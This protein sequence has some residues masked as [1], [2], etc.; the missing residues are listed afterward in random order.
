MA[1]TPTPSST[2]YVGYVQRQPPI[3][4]GAVATDVIDRLGKV[5]EKHAATR[6]K[7]DTMTADA[8]TA[9]GE[10]EG[11]KS[12]DLD[13]FVYDG[14]IQARNLITA[15]YDKLKRGDISPDQ[16]NRMRMSVES[17]WKDLSTVMTNYNKGISLAM[18]SLDK[19]NSSA[20]LQKVLEKL[21]GLSELGNKKLTWGLQGNGFAT[22]AVQE[23]NDAGAVG[24]PTSMRTLINPNNLIFPKTQLDQ[25]LK[26]LRQLIGK[27]SDKG[28]ISD[29]ANADY[30][31]AKTD[32]INGQLSSDKAIGSILVD[33]GGY[34]PYMEGDEVPDKGVKIFVNENNDISME[35]DNTLKDAAKKI[36]ENKVALAE[37]EVTPPTATYRGKDKYDKCIARG[38]EW[39]FALDK[40]VSK[41]TTLDTKDQELA[42]KYDIA[43]AA[44]SGIF[45]GLDNDNYEYTIHPSDGTLKIDKVTGKKRT[46]IKDVKLG[47]FEAAKLL[48]AYVPGFSVAEFDIIHNKIK[49][50][51]KDVKVR[52]S[53]IEKKDIYNKSNIQAI[54]DINDISNK[55]ETSVH[56]AVTTF[57]H[58]YAPDA[59]VTFGKEKKWQSGKF[60][61]WMHM[62]VKINGKHAGFIP[63]DIGSGT[64]NMD[65]ILAGGSTEPMNV[66]FA[67]LVKASNMARESEG[68]G[69]LD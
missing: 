22:L 37:D 48:S 26:S 39:D 9:V 13:N 4:W 43:K 50:E 56:D 8:M 36:V 63:Y 46:I 45:T 6:E 21:G 14:T 33:V 40:C 11:G 2:S 34:I 44:S 38:G 55:D 52:V 30:Q 15:Y 27:R 69:E 57:I 60:D 1:S 20:I 59:E 16:Y 65:E 18:E 10:Y 58:Q 62:S 12:Q 61:D 53:K 54:L 24:E 49:G 5:E 47:T 25:D 67:T 42:A 66:A 68:G 17:Q 28:V 7:Y 32:F 29:A 51:E 3:D 64:L 35:I 41:K 19:G 23:F 31:K